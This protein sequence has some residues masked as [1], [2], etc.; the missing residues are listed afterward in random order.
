MSK[1]LY[2]T[3]V[4][5]TAP[6]SS[7]AGVVGQLYLDTSTKTLYQYVATNEWQAIN[8]F[9][10]QELTLTESGN[11]LTS[12]ETFTQHVQVMIEF[13][14]DSI[15]AGFDLILHP[16]D[17]AICFVTY[18]VLVNGTPNFGTAYLNDLGNVVIN[19]PTGLTFTNIHAHYI[20]L[21]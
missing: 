21:E 16:Y 8:R 9:T 17:E 15:H 4:E 2:T 3:Y 10:P 20:N 18:D 11:V 19:V 12:T 5:S 7:T 14:T 1:S 6:T 13:E